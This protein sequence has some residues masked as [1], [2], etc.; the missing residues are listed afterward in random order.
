MGNGEFTE[1]PI[2]SRR[3]IMEQILLGYDPSTTIST[4]SEVHLD[5]RALWGTCRIGRSKC[6]KSQVVLFHSSKVASKSSSH[7]KSVFFCLR[8]CTCHPYQHT[9][10][11]FRCLHVYRSSNTAQRTLLY[12]CEFSSSVHAVEAMR[13]ETQYAHVLANAVCLCFNG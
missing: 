12:S 10:E 2:V 13:L 3:M 7:T 1:K 4:A 9:N 8:L 6:C 5:C 11:K